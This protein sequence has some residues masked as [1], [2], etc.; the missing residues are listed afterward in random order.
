MQKELYKPS[1]CLNLKPLISNNCRPDFDSWTDEGE[2]ALLDDADSNEGAIGATRAGLLQDD[3]LDDE[4]YL[5]DEYDNYDAILD[6]KDQD[7][8]DLASEAVIPPPFLCLPS[9]LALLSSVYTPKTLLYPEPP[10]PL[11]SHIL[12]NL[13]PCSS[14]PAFLQS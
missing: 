1:A 5:D 8:L 2:Q 14:T 9:F 11:T 4:Q 3:L 10:Y 13:T 7:P 6:M 12:P